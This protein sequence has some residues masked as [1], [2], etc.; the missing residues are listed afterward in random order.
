SG[1]VGCK[2]ILEEYLPVPVIERSG[3]SYTLN[4]N[5]EKSVGR[6]K[7]FYGNFLVVLKAYTYMLSLGGNGLREVSESAVLNANYMLNGLRKY[8][9]VEYSSPCMHE[10]V[11]GLESFKERTGVSAIDVA[12]SM[13]DKGFHP[14][15][16]YFPLIVHEALMFEPTETESKETLDNALMEI[17][18]ILE[19][20]YTDAESLHAAPVTTPVG[21]PDEVVAAR[22]PRLRYMFPE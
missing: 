6:V 16:M 11:I 8:S 3:E 17:C 4:Y 9:D 7:M 12:K 14:P 18:E 22:Q 19:R 13:I 2:K 1:P 21:R 10:F 20:A 5:R 15:T